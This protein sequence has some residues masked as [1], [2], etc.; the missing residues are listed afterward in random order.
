MKTAALSKIADDVN[1]T[2]LDGHDQTVTLTFIGGTGSVTTTTGLNLLEGTFTDDL[3][4]KFIGSLTDINAA[5]DSLIF[6]PETDLNGRNAGGIYIF[7]DDDNGLNM[8]RTVR[9]DIDVANVAP[10]ITDE[11]IFTLDAVDEDVASTGVL[12]SAILAGVNVADNDMGANRGIAITS[13]TGTGSWEFSTNDTN[14]TAFGVVGN[15]SALLLTSTSYVRLTGDADVAGDATFGFKAW[16]QTTGD[17]STN[18]IPGKADTTTNGTTTAFSTENATA[19][20]TVNPVNDAPVLNLDTDDNSGAGG[21]NFTTEYYAGGA[22]VKI[23]DIDVSITDVDDANIESAQVIL[24]DGF[25]DGANE[26]ISIN[27]TPANIGPVNITYTSNKRIDLA[28]QAT[29]AEYQTAIKAIEYSHSAALAAVTTGDRTVTVT[30]NDGD[31]NS[32]IAKHHSDGY[33]C[34][35]GSVGDL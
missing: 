19:A 4:M 7:T 10:T 20:I 22:V 21:N 11:A 30:V 3:V 32:N 9:F 6:T 31:I 15:N 13:V 28:G 5:L 35:T 34:T 8:G 24:S 16:D 17:A 14:W 18:G 33:W 1:V 26:T 29:I 2:D 12:V 25:P 27:A 23:A